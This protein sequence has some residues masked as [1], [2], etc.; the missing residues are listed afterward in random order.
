MTIELIAYVLLP[1]LSLGYLAYR[2]VSLWL[3][4]C[5]N[6][7][8]Y[9]YILYGL[10]GVFCLAALHTVGVLLAYWLTTSF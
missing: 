7:P 8:Y 6:R 3:S 9:Y 4:L 1:S 2:V 10:A 5:H